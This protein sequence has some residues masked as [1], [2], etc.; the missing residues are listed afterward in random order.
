[1][2]YSFSRREKILLAVL[3]LIVLGALWYVL[4]YTGCADSYT[5][6]Q[7]AI[8]NTQTDIDTATVKLSKM[9]TMQS[10]LAALQKSGA[11][12]TTLP[13]YDNVQNLTAQ[14]NTILSAA[15]TYNLSFESPEA[16]TDNV[17][18]RGVTLTFGC[19]S[20]ATAKSI[21]TQLDQSSFRCLIDTV[22]LSQA[23]T[24]S[25]K[26]T[27]A[28]TVAGSTSTNASSSSA[29]SVSMHLTY[30]ETTV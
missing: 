15:D 17:M 21:I 5:R 24:S 10:E 1:M 16:G 4:V 11:T 25:T 30:F 19:G 13:K 12:Q 26:T 3:I 8:D 20:Y 27:T 6:A 28:T 14:L 7:T 2:Q 18:R 23:G 9:K 22:S 29:V